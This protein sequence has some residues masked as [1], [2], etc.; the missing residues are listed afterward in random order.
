MRDAKQR[1]TSLALRAARL[2]ARPFCARSLEEEVFAWIPNLS[3]VNAINCGYQLPE[4]G[5]SLLAG[6]CE[7]IL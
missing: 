7:V 2:R 1:R 3:Q 5:L 6:E 4:F